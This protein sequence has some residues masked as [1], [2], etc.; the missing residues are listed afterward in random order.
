LLSDRQLLPANTNLDYFARLP[1]RLVRRVADHYGLAVEKKKLD[2]SAE[3][4]P[5]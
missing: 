2:V 4:F 5:I 3:L 1:L